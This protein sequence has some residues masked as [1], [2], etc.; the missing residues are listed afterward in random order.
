MNLLIELYLKK[1][2]PIPKIKTN[3]YNVKFKKSI[4]NKIII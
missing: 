3:Q 1:K 4:Y 2:V